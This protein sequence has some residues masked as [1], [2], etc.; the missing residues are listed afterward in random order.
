LDD[1]AAPGSLVEA[2]GVL[3]DDRMDGPRVLER[4]ESAM[5]GVGLGSGPPVLQTVAP[6][7][8]GVP[9]EL[10]DGSHAVGIHSG[11]QPALA[12]KDRDAALGRD[13]SAGEGDASPASSQE[14]GRALEGLIVG[15]T[16]LSPA[17]RSSSG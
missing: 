12:P 5:R 8:A 13:A 3:S 7:G 2:V 6:V 10:L 16:H 4:F 14:L 9:A 1:V 15:R 11:P 17:K